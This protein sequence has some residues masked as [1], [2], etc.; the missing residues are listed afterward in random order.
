MCLALGIRGGCEETGGKRG[1]IC[2]NIHLGLK[3]LRGGVLRTVSTSRW[4]LSPASCYLHL[5]TK[6]YR[7]SVDLV[8]LEG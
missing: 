1:R 4:C 8:V 6:V 7:G 3:G 5:Q 2:R